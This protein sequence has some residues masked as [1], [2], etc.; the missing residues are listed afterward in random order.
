M[1]IA[2]DAGTCGS[3]H[4]RSAML[5]RETNP[6]SSEDS[7]DVSVREDD[8]VA[9]YRLQVRYDPVS[10]RSDTLNALAMSDTVCPE[11]PTWDLGA[12]LL[13]GAP[14]VVSVIP[15]DQVVEERYLA[16]ITGCDAGFYSAFKRA[17]EH[18]RERDAK[19]SEVVAS[20]GSLKE[21]VSI[22]RDVGEAGV[23]S[24][25][26]PFGLAVPYENDLTSRCLA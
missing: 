5:G 23:P 1:L 11:G 17:G 13:G 20:V 12:D 15:F 22:K 25:A 19:V 14:L 21:S 18:F 10:A 4:E 9:V 26:A 24:H 8:D 3:E 2:E 16:G 7:K 6:A